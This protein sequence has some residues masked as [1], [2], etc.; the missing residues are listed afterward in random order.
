MKHYCVFLMTHRSKALSTGVTNHLEQRMNE[1]KPHLVAGLTSKDQM[2]RLVSFEET[3]EVNA[4]LAG[5]KH[6]K[7]WVRAKNMEVA[8]HGSHHSACTSQRQAGN[9]GCWHHR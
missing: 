4:A 3:S 2:T 5:E 8:T 1:H 6:R 7:G 9:L